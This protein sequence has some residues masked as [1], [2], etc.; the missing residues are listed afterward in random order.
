M[1]KSEYKSPEDLPKAFRAVFEEANDEEVPGRGRCD[2]CHTLCSWVRSQTRHPGQAT[3]KTAC[4]VGYNLESGGGCLIQFVLKP[5]KV[6]INQAMG[7]CLHSIKYIAPE[8]WPKV[9]KYALNLLLHED[10]RDG[11]Y[12]AFSV[13]SKSDFRHPETAKLFWESPVSEHY[14]S[15]ISLDSYSFEQWWATLS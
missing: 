5:S 14:R 10:S 12:G 9:D 4:R 3:L 1:S 11:W 8:D 15:L 13:Y 2:T 6:D 7:S